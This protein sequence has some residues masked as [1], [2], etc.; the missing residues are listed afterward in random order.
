MRWTEQ[1]KAAMEPLFKKLS[2]VADK[3]AKDKGYD[4]VIDRSALIVASPQNDL[5]SEVISR[6]DRSPH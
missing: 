1:K 2:E 5:T 3:V 6:L 4:L